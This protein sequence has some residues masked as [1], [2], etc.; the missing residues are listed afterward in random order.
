MNQAKQY[1][2]LLVVLVVLAGCSHKTSNAVAVVGAGYPDPESVGALVFKQ[3]CADCH[4]PPPP[5]SRKAHDW[6]Q[7]V[8]RMQNHRIMNNF[9]P[10]TNDEMRQILDYLQKYSAG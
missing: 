5:A 9:A 3:R 2:L 4:V 8:G 10:I 7:I 1:A 6:P